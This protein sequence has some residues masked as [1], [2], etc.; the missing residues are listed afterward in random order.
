MSNIT[1]SAKGEEGLIRIPG[2]CNH[3]PETT[4]FCH[5]GGGGMGMKRKDI[6]GAYGCS[7]C[8]DI[9]DGRA[10]P[11]RWTNDLYSKVWFYEGV[12]RTQEILLEKGL[13]TLK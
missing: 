2:A 13:I 5:L 11:D 6:H 10:K 7:D 12:F 1:K 9:V 4:V 3:N 8:H